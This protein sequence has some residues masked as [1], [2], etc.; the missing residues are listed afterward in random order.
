MN[1][2]HRGTYT[3]THTQTPTLSLSHTHTHAQPPSSLDPAVPP[4]SSPRVQPLL[5]GRT[6]ILLPGDAARRG[7]VDLPGRKQV[8]RHR[9]EAVRLSG[10]TGPDRWV[11]VRWESAPP[12]RSSVCCHRRLFAAAG[13]SR[14]RLQIFSPAG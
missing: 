13:R 10:S 8:H 2:C 7:P 1:T 14:C 3:Y 9:D 4:S 11:R 6:L 5:S 12:D